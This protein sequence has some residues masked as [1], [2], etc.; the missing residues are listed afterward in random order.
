MTWRKTA[1]AARGAALQPSEAGCVETMQIPV[2]ARVLRLRMAPLVGRVRE[3]T[4]P[5]SQVGA[6]T[7]ACI[8]LIA[9]ASSFQIANAQ[10]KPP[11]DPFAAFSGSLTAVPALRHDPLD[12][13]GCGQ[14]VVDQI[15]TPA[16]PHDARG[17]IVRRRR[18]IGILLR[19]P[20]RRTRPGSP[21]Q[22]ARRVGAG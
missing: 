16:G 5:K 13:F 10:S 17:E 7:A 20:I 4:V 6:A 11:I 15:N 14:D 12:D 9:M 1:A 19:L 3:S 22:V 2:D 21:A 18:Q 8:A